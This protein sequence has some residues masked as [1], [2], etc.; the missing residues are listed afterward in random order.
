MRWEGLGGLRRHIMLRDLFTQKCLQKKLILDTP[1]H[2][3]SKKPNS[4]GTPQPTFFK[5]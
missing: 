5:M 1:E 2:V 3:D 4:L